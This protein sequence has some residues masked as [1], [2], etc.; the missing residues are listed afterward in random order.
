[1]KHV[2]NCTGYEMLIEDIERAEGNYLYDSKGRKYVDFESGV[3]SIS[4]GHSC[5]ELNEVIRNQ[6][7]KIIHLGFK[8]TSQL[9]EIAAV[10]LLSTL[11]P[12][13]GKCVFLCSGSEAVEL[14]V[15]AARHIIKDKMLLSFN[16]S[17]L[18]AYGHSGVK[19][20]RE[21]YK[22]DL[23][24]CAACSENACCSECNVIN[25]IPFDRIGAFVFEPGNSSGLV[26]IPPKSVI[27]EIAKRVKQNGGLIVVDEVTTGIGRTGK[28]FGYQHYDM[29]PDIVAVGK[30]IGN[31]Y[32]VSVTV[33]D[34][35]VAEQ[36]QRDGFK[37]SQSHQNDALGCAVVSKVIGIIRENDLIN[38]SN[39]KG[40]YLLSRLNGLKVKT[41]CI[42]D[43]RGT[44]LM[45]GI[46]FKA[47]AADLLKSA[48]GQLFNEG[49]LVGYN[50]RFN[51]MRFYPTLTT[52]M[53]DIEG[54]LS[55]L[56][57][58]LTG[59]RNRKL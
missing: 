34:D 56:E 39:E 20:D 32:P 51:F 11:Q 3:W 50:P 10:D 23:L 30:G 13:S 40:Q 33:F 53:E 14:A 57:E 18:S 47:E 46:E 7:D 55:C 21:W 28:W 59:K 16:M 31:G 38:K 45:I 9:V 26:L 35:R 1:M 12:F 5:N 54:L 41:D 58:I 27:R 49:Y 24:K 15:K 29:Q 43:V 44:G 22:P 25:E 37:H 52:S 36:L 6:A 17:Y 42:K 48:V 19:D 2:M 4:L 8:Y